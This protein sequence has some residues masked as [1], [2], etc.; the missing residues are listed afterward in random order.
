MKIG[1]IADDFT[2]SSDIALTLAEAG[3]TVTQF[4]GVP[5]GDAGAVEAGV[6]ALK[7]GGPVTVGEGPIEVGRAGQ[8][9]IFIGGGIL[10]QP[11]AT[12]QPEE[13]RHPQHHEDRPPLRLYHVHG[14]TSLSCRIILSVGPS[15][16]QLLVRH[17]LHQ[18]RALHPW[19]GLHCC[20]RSSYHLGRSGLLDT[21]R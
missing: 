19:A 18:W 2:G 17:R 8:P 14:E 12:G 15:A 5:E 11:K 21:Y 1:V 10:G 4:I 20:K 6:V 13:E 3:L 16:H 9:G 7:G